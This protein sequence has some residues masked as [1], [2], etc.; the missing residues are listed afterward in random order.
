MLD[1]SLNELRRLLG[2]THADVRAAMNDLLGVTFDS[3]AARPLLAR[4]IELERV[5][6]S[7]DP[8]A[9]AEQLNRRA[10]ERLNV[11]QYGEAA[12]L[13]QGALDIVK[14]QLPP[15]HEDVRTVQRNLAAA[16]YMGGKLAEAESMQRAEVALETR[17]NGSAVSRGMAHEALA[18]TFYAERRADS[19]E[20]EERAAL[21]ALRSGAAPEHWRIWSAQRNLAIMLAAR[22]RVADGLAL[23][24]SAIALAGAGRDSSTEVGYLTAQR[25]PFLLRLQRATEASQAVALSERM[26]GTSPA[27]SRSH[28]ADVHRYAGMVALATGNAQLAADRFRSAVNLVEPPDKPETVPDIHSCLLGVSLARLGRSAE[29][30]PLLDKPCTAYASH[31]MPDALIMEWISA[32][33]RQMP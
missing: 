17:L 8:I 22:G 3:M 30:R 32:A 28:R 12:A 29:A 9:V 23:L 25:I 33:R 7:K 6:P 27:V 4:L 10:T 1:S 21:E 16:L 20:S 19:A 31:G 2:E 5:S 11:R 15:E 24:D 13:F 18:L 14:R 26:L